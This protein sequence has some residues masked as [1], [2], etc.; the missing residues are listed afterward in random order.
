LRCVPYPCRAHCPFLMAVID[1]G[2]EL[3]FTVCLANCVAY[4]RTAPLGL[5]SQY[6]R[7]FN[8]TI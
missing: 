1:R 2:F 3:F 4:Y 7:C 5:G 6:H 8:S